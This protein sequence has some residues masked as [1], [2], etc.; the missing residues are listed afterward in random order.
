MSTKKTVRKPA[1]KKSTRKTAAKVAHREGTIRSELQKLYD[2]Y[3]YADAKKKA[4]EQG[5]NR[6]TVQ[7]QLWLINKGR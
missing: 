1:K 6:F 7:R 2:K 4:I 3:G 5:Y